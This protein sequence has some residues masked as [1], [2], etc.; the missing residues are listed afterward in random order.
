[1]NGQRCL[2]VTCGFLA[3]LAVLG[4]GFCALTGAFVTRAVAVGVGRTAEVAVHSIPDW[5]FGWGDRHPFVINADIPALVED[6]VE[7]AVTGSGICNRVEAQVRLSPQAQAALGE[8]IGEV[9]VLK[10][11][12]F[13]FD[14][15]TGGRAGLKLEVRG[16]H[17][18]GELEVVAHRGSGVLRLGRII[19]LRVGDSEWDFDRLE[20]YLPDRQEHIDLLNLAR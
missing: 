16:P 4:M 3:V 17:G 2:G 13:S 19:T 7:H 12:T 9:A 14:P 8:P 18:K 5:A 1:M 15:V 6:L 11:H 10:V 20:L